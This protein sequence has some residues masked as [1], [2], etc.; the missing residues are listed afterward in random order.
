MF[1]EL[2]P[3]LRQRAV[4][5]T[6]THLEDDQIRVNVV[7]QKI[8]DGDNAALTTPLTVTGTPEE[9]DRDLPTTLVN[10]VGAHLGLKNTLDRVKEEMDTAAKVAQAEARSKNKSAGIKP[11]PK[12]EVTKPAETPKP[13]PPPPSEPARAASL[14]DA[15]APPATS[16]ADTDEEEEILAETA[17]QEQ[18]DGED[19][20]YGAA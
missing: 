5:L 10:F 12:A 15:P 17:E 20:E 16:I 7:P 8:K 9:L 19:E 2:A 3:L 14:F 4:L 18:F 13:A 6:V 1:Q 11:P